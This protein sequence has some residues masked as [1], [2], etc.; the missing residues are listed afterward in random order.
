MMHRVFQIACVAMHLVLLP[1]DATAGTCSCQ[2]EIRNAKASVTGLCAKIWSHNVCTLK[3]DGAPPLQSGQ[4][5][6]TTGSGSAQQSQQAWT[7]DVVTEVRR[8]IPG[9]IRIFGGN[10]SDLHP[11]LRDAGFLNSAILRTLASETDHR[12]VADVLKLISRNESNI[13]TSWS[14][15]QPV[16]FEEGDIKAAVGFHCIYAQTRD[17]RTN[18]YL[19]AS[20]IGECTQVIE[21]VR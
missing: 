18:F 8:S 3:E 2:N 5:G 6:S 1:L 15:P 19:N 12:F 16:S 11:Q 13:Q 17:G 21:A 14:R 7:N 4:S 20:P 10:V 9:S